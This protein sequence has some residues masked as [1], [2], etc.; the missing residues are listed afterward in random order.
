ME[1]PERAN[2]PAQEETR[3]WSTGSVITKQTLRVLAIHV[4]GPTAPY[5]R[6]H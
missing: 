3:R 4:K 1:K 2:A 6:W 5:Q